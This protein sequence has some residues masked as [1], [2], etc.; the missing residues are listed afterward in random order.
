MSLL[1]VLRTSV[2]TF[3]FPKVCLRWIVPTGYAG[4]CL[5]RVQQWLDTSTSKSTV[6][7]T[8]CCLVCQPFAKCEQSL[9]YVCRLP[10]CNV[11]QV[12]QCVVKVCTTLI[13]SG[14]LSQETT[15]SFLG[16]ATERTTVQ[17]VRPPRSRPV[18]LEPPCIKS[19]VKLHNPQ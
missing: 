19:M 1:P 18:G 16:M 13:K 11:A 9:C 5:H 15:S 3:N 2:G 10:S 17:E 14:V 7:M 6:S 4:N 8:S 12:T